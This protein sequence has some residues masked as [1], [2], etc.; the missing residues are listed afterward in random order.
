MNVLLL[1][2]SARRNGN[3]EQMLEAAAAV[4]RQCGVETEIL[5]LGGEA[6][7]DCIGCNGC[8]NTH[9]CVFDGDG[10]NALLDQAKLADGF[11]FGTPVY[12]AHPSGRILSLLDRAFYAGSDAFRHK[13]GAAVAVAR[14][15]GT[16][17]SLDVLNKYFTI[18]EM[19]VVSSS[20]WNVG[21]G[22]R[23]GE[24]DA[25]GEGLQT[26]RNLGRN[27]AWLLHCIEAGR[28]A[29]IRPP[30]NEYGTMTNFI[31]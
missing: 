6:L 1:N 22:A 20:Y 17:A 10:V 8:R 30:E 26:M 24:V 21:H 14:R 18:A 11:I 27:M 19:P 7:R 28:Q 4:L 13:P 15:A 2:G 29:G 5:Q 31:R 12:Y 23:P 16:T 9:H 25:D 3:T